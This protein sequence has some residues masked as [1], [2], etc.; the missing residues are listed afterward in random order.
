MIKNK[1]E[2]SNILVVG[3]SGSLREGSYTSMAVKIALE[4]A[5]E[6]GVQTDFIDLNK[7]SLVFC[8]GRREESTYPEDVFKLKRKVSSAQGIILGTPEYHGGL[9]GVLKN[10]VDLM[11]FDEFEGKMI[12][13]IGVSGGSMGAANALISLRNIGRAL[14]AWIIPEQVSIGEAWKLFDETGEI[15]DNKL[16]QRVKEVGR[17]VARFAYLHTSEQTKEFLSAWEGAPKNPGG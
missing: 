13:L 1:N 16:N 14:H 4:A 15:K 12:G 6:A 5:Q 7:Y 2:E 9:S 11:G 3:L 8:D 10:A 17:Q